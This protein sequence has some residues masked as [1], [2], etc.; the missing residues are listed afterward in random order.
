ML[1]Q[2]RYRNP[3]SPFKV[4]WFRKRCRI[5]AIN[6]TTWLG[7]SWWAVGLSGDKWRKSMKYCKYCARNS[8]SFMIFHRTESTTADTFLIHQDISSG[9]GGCNLQESLVWAQHR[10][11]GPVQ[12][13]DFPS[14]AWW[15]PAGQGAKSL[16]GSSSGQSC[17]H[18]AAGRGEPQSVFAR[19]VCGWQL[20]RP[21]IGWVFIL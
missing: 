3:H 14:L 17:R 1:H 9:I 18:S 5:L 19:K 2:F 10:P 13:S 21:L 16:W 11:R 4:R 8:I 6:S 15:E 20:L 12:L 7:T